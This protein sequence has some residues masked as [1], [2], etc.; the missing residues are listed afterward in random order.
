MQRQGDMVV[1]TNNIDQSVTS[2]VNLLR[3]DKL[4][5]DDNRELVHNQ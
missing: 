5:D 3:V 4:S 2:P 1:T